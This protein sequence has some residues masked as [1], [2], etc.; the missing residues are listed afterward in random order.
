M[1]N[2]KAV[3]FDLDGTL[4][5]TVPAINRTCNLV[6]EFFSL[7]PI[8]PQEVKRFAGD[9]VAQ[10]VERALLHAGGQDAYHNFFSSACQRYLE[11]FEKNCMYNVKPYPG[12]PETLRKLREAGLR[13]AVLT[14]KPQDR[15]EDNI[16]GLFGTALF[17]EIIGIVPGRQPK[18]DTTALL[19]LLR[20]W[21]LAPQECLYVGDT[22]T[23]MRTAQR[24]SL[25][26]AAA[27]WGFRGREELAEFSPEYMVEQPA[28]LLEIFDGGM[29][30]IQ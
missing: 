15:A 11:F 14:N 1:K 5:D 9:G 20:R 7:P 10:L 3:I 12:M 25:P 28:G 2:A 18:P 16:L 8:G 24:A 6:L 27:L 30:G 23:D 13:L 17:D 4:L 19:D 26:K 21:R 29:P 22:N